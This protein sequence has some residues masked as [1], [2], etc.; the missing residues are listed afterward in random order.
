MG[1]EWT[2]GKEE[3]KE[4]KGKT[5]SVNAAHPFFKYAFIIGV[6]ILL[7]SIWNKWVALISIALG[8][9][10][11]YSYQNHDTFWEKLGLK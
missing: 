9:G 6:F 4:K 10:I 3:K 5:F 7:S 8:A 11:G 2:I 1:L